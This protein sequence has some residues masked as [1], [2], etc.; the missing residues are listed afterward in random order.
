MGGTRLA[1]ARIAELKK[2]I[3]HAEQKKKEFSDYLRGLKQ[4][5]HRGEISYSSFLEHF[6]QKRNGLNLKEWL[7]HF[8]DYIK[9]CKKE[10]RKERIKLLGNYSVFAFLSLVFISIF[11]LAFSNMNIGFTG[12]AIQEG[13]NIS[14]NQS[15]SEEINGEVQNETSPSHQI[16]QEPLPPSENITANESSISGNF[17]SGNL[18]EQNATEINQTQINETQNISAENETIPIQ[19]ITN[20]TTQNIAEQNITQQNVSIVEDATINTTQVTPKIKLGEKVKWKKTISSNEI[21]NATII[22]PKNSENITI[23][24]IKENK[25]EDITSSSSITGA[26]V[27]GSRENFIFRLLK[28]IFGRITGRIVD[29]IARQNVSVEVEIE[30]DEIQAEYEVEYETPAPYSIEEDIAFGKRVKIFGPD[31]VHYENVLAFTNI[32]ENLNLKNPSKIKIK[33]IE[34][35]IYINPDS[36]LDSDENGIYDYVEWNVPSLS[37]QTFEIIVITKA[38]HLD[39]NYNFVSDIYEQVKE[40]DGIWSEEIPDA[41]YVRVTFEKNLTNENDITIYPRITS[42]NPTI[43]VYE[44]NGNDLVAEFSSLNENEYNKV[45]LTNL[46]SESQNVF[47][48]K[49]VGGTIQ[50]DY[51]VDPVEVGFFDDFEG[52]L[53]KW[54]TTSWVVTT[55]QFKN[56][57]QSL[58]SA[59]G[60]EGDIIT[61]PFDTSNATS[62]NISFWFRDNNLDAGDIDFYFFNGTSSAY[63]LQTE[64]LE[65][66][67]AEDI[68]TFKSFTTSNSEFFISNFSVRFN[69]NLG[70]G[71]NFWV[72]DFSV[73]KTTVVVDSTSPDVTINVPQNTTYHVHFDL[74]FNFNVS[75]NEAG[76]ALY[77]L[78][79]GFTNITMNTTD[80]LNFNATLLDLTE[81]S[82]TFQVY[83]N[84]TAGNANYSESVVFDLVM[85]NMLV[86]GTTV[87]PDGMPT[88]T[89]FVIIDE[90]SSNVVYNETN[91]THET[92]IPLNSTYTI[93]VLPLEIDSVDKVEFNDVNFSE[94]ND[95]VTSIVKINENETLGNFSTVFSVRP[96]FETFENGTLF[97]TAKANALF[98]CGEWNYTMESCQG[99]WSLFMNDLIPGE[100]YNFTFSGTRGYGIINITN[101]THLDSNRSYISD[102]YDYVKEYDGNWSEIIPD[103]HYVRVV[104]QENLTSGND[105]TIV[106]RNLS[107]DARVEVYENGQDVLLSEFYPLIEGELNQIL[108]TNLT[109]TQDVFDLR[110][111]GNDVEFDYIVDPNITVIDTQSKDVGITPINSTAFVIVWNNI[112]SDVASN[113][114]FFKIMTTTG[115]IVLDTV[116]VDENNPRVSVAALNSTTFALVYVNASTADELRTV[117]TTDGTK[118]FGPTTDDGSIG[119]VGW[120]VSAT[121]INETAYVSCYVDMGTDGDGDV[122]IINYNAASSEI[123]LNGDID[124]NQNYA[125][126]FDCAT[127]N[128]TAWAGVTYDAVDADVGLAVY[129][130]RGTAITALTLID[131][132]VGTG[133]AQVSVTGLNGENF[134]MVWFTNLS[135]A[136]TNISATVRTANNGVVTAKTRIVNMPGNWTRIDAATVANDTGD[137][138]VLGWINLTTKGV[139]A[140][141]FKQD[142]TP[143]SGIITIDTAMNREYPLF[144]IIG[145]TTTTSLCN[146]T[147][148]IAYTN[149]TNSTVVKTY[150]MNGSIW[151]GVCPAPADNTKPAISIFSP[152]NLTNTTDNLIDILATYSDA[153]GLSSAWYN[154]DTHAV[155]NK[156]LGTVGS[157]TNITNLTWGEGG[158][159]VTVYVSDTAGNENWTSV[160]FEVD[161]IKPAI[162]IVSPAINNSNSS[163]TALDITYT[164]SDAHLFNF[165]Y[166]NDTTTGANK[167]L[168]VL[169]TSFNITNIT[170]GE[171]KHNV[172]IYANDTFGNV[173]QTRISFTIDSTKPLVTIAN[174][175]TNNTNTSDNLLDINY[176]PT[177][178]FTQIDS[179]WYTNN[180]GNINKSLGTLGSLTNISNITWG[181]G[182]HNVTIYTNDTAGN[183]NFTT[184]SFTVDTVIPGISID[185]PSNLTNSS[186]PGLDVNFIASDSG[187]GLFNFWYA[188]DTYSVANKS[189]GVLGT[190]FNITN[191]TWGEGNH[192]VTIWANDSAGNYNFAS[193]TFEVDSIKPAIEIVSPTGNNTNTSDT[194]LDVTYTTSDLH[195]FNFW[196]NND[197]HAA[198]NKSLGVLGTSFNITNI[199]WGEGKH[200]V[201]IYSNDTFGNV[202]F[203]TTSFTIDSTL[204]LITITNPASNNT[205]T[206]DNG[207]DVNYVATDTFTQISSAW[208]TNNSGNINKSL[209]VLGSLTNISN[210]T[211]GEGKHNVTIY[212]NDSAGNVNFT[213][214]SF[215]IDTIQPTISIASPSNNSNSSDTGLDVLYIPTDAGSGLFN[216]WYNNDTYTAANKSL[217]V[218]GTSFNI[219]NLTWGEGKHNVTIWANDSAGNY[220]F[221]SISFT[222]DTINPDLNITYP[223]NNSVVSDI[224][225]DINYTRLDSGSGL[226]NCWYSN[227]TY[228]ANTTLSN[229]ENVTAVIWGEGAH[230]AT[231]W[232]NDSSGNLNKTSVTFTISLNNPPEIRNIYNDTATIIAAASGISSGPLNTSLIVNFSVYDANGVANMD[233]STA[234]VNFS[235]SGEALR[236][237]PTCD[238]VEVGTNVANY[239]CNVT[240]SWY[241][242]AGTWAVQAFISDLD[243]NDAKNNSAN[244]SVGETTGFESG[245]LTF[246]FLSPGLKNQTSAVA[247]RLNNTG[248]KNMA[249]N[250]T[251]VNATNLR[252]EITSAF[253]IWSGNISTSWDST[254]LEA[255]D[256]SGGDGIRANNMSSGNYVNITTANLTKGNYFVNDGSTG[257][258]D[259]YFCI[260]TV[261]AELTSQQYSTA[262]EGAWTIRILLAF[263]AIPRKRKKKTEKDKLLETISLLVDEFKEKHRLSKEDT[264]NLV[265]KEIRKKYKINRSEI[266]ELSEVKKISIPATIFSEKMG[267]LESL[268]K[269]MKENLEMSYKEIA[270]E[271][272]RDERTIWTSYK[273]AVE[274]QKEVIEET[275]TNITIPLSIFKDSKSTI[276][277]S[278]VVYLKENGMRYSEIGELL[279]RDQRNIW[280]IYDRA[281][282]K[283]R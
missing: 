21:G 79:N 128:S 210:I 165:W 273:N 89:T 76:N 270:E 201:T 10:I 181:E 121:A 209:G 272:N 105:I 159:N 44:E 111:S 280:T 198:A 237:S 239:S 35:N 226:F 70:N 94:I 116:K 53:A 97:F 254:T 98:R 9:D 95:T 233:N 84:D 86:N 206:S 214:I 266:L 149:F 186:N 90:S 124:A 32:S 194:A 91:D 72:D 212:T 193:V 230:N 228:L 250:T 277:E 106:P 63:E 27:G 45:F 261:G 235:K 71:E 134:A 246:P 41:H 160:T 51:I 185:S 253:A 276:L 283:K 132:S 6:Y 183:V 148:A 8:D 2:R 264:M 154:N 271:I 50:I 252:G 65:T 138:L 120:D 171:G 143:A 5:Y 114:S 248:N 57:A 207:L 123:G 182:K 23:T 279:N 163:D 62:I 39:E 129:N 262:N 190:S 37:E 112:S 249:A 227:D 125:N 256:T 153:G 202:N 245:S 74:P 275:E 189:L 33:W 77:S 219:T 110:V 133:G 164:T 101:A 58:Q 208:Y 259:F 15:I 24:K 59:N 48:L 31:A 166:A 161:S 122:H 234:T 176:I 43:E 223:I 47:D 269:Y 147:F 136:D 258:E 196:Y 267:I 170:W 109:G 117:W 3:A 104:F 22:L 192:N 81:G 140:Q 221:A 64:T 150:W 242:G 34:Q 87:A 240:M 130:D 162:E 231:I 137:Y 274:K 68:W 216:F 4:K 25:E 113:G 215:T 1:K 141:T 26:V 199:T 28:N 205:N 265:I 107:G 145:K 197:T 67:T 73:N 139:L 60:Q 30:I 217:G 12:F 127:I 174:P 172:T 278:I 191:I 204:P 103:G 135:T 243:S 158:H 236:Q 177:D 178:T 146:E 18:T 152:A 36:V 119:V 49:V 69:A 92:L 175:T 187:S 29:E 126:L 251:Q 56:G 203:T 241:D 247:L 11:F 263:V 75:L 99:N 46:I 78:D 118:V 157:F 55:A 88:N 184:I 282:K 66:E 225:A 281:A 180:S 213:T 188:N 85:D 211:W 131:T 173:N 151:N 224:N 52:T 155:A 82:Y 96:Q 14:A 260:K 168:G 40:L 93:E 229:C 38:E 17:S 268:V 7:L 244:F 83:A 144:D 42:G 16:G 257:Q 156:S 61:D 19:N 100:E 200:N 13:E 142:L 20:Q 179:A 108:L 222:I 102:I 220:N 80:N 115:S 195:L 255:C 167:S 54:G 218:L 232:A 238:Q 169:G